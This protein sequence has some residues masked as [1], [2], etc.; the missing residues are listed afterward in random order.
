MEGA[1][2]GKRGDR[3]AKAEHLFLCS[4]NLMVMHM[5]DFGF[6]S[7]SGKISS[8]YG[9]CIQ[10][11]PAVSTSLDLMKLFTTGAAQITLL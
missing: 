10:L 3:R 5:Y 1:P 4:S 2:S 7:L 6:G 8:I 9:V 11:W